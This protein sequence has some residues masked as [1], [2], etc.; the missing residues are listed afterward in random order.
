MNT[1]TTAYNQFFN[2][3]DKYTRSTTTY[4]PDVLN[5]AQFAFEKLKKHYSRATQPVYTISQNIG[6]SLPLYLMV[7]R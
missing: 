4:D 5:A 6:S 1:A 7:L 3:L 2:H